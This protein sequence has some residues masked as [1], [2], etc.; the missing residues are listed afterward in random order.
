MTLA[1][2]PRP[3]ELHALAPLLA[4]IT[5][6]AHRHVSRVHY[7]ALLFFDTCL[8]AAVF[9]IF[10]FHKKAFIRNRIADYCD[11]LFDRHKQTVWRG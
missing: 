10:L 7:R 3:P 9:I 6:S 4:L 8:L 11:K 5:C 2:G 1:P